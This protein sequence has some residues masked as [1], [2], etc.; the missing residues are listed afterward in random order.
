MTLRFLSSALLAAALG[1]L[2][3]PATA[4]TMPYIADKSA[5]SCVDQARDSAGTWR[6]AC[7]EHGG[8]Q[9][10]CRI[11]ARAI[12]EFVLSQCFSSRDQVV[13]TRASR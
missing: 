2:L 11:E 1:G 5:F 7:I 12:Y 4:Q 8:T 3:A 6:N 9:H 13:P 10:E